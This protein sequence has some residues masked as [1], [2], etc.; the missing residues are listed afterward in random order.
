MPE[1]Q[2]EAFVAPERQ[3]V[4]H[5]HPSQFSMIF[6]FVVSSGLGK[7]RA[8]VL[9][10][11]FQFNLGDSLT[12]D[13]SRA[14]LK[15]ARAHDYTSQYFAQLDLLPIYNSNPTHLSAHLKNQR[16]NQ[17]K[18]AGINPRTSRARVGS[19]AAERTRRGACHERAKPQ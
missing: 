18:Q 15:N 14:I 7:T 10:G 1:G 17:I 19:G 13:Y 3:K 11:C 8:C 16:H 9:P 2:T 4:I 6:S 5:S 12:Y